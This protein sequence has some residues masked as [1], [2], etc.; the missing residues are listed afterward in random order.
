MKYILFLKWWLIFT[1]ISVLSIFTFYSGFAKEIWIKDSSYISYFTF[2]IFF[3]CTIFC[4]KLSHSI[5]KQ[6]EKIDSKNIIEYIHNVEIGWFVSELCLTLGMI[7]TIVG[8]IMMLSGFNTLDI[9]NI[10]TVQ[11]LLSQLGQSMATALYTTVVGLVCGSI[12]KAQCFLLSV[13]L[14]KIEQSFTNKDKSV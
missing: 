8:F 1:I 6:H 11:Q 13:E 5:C 12:L 3:I 7:G 2:L 9:Q 14:D 10:Q 4:G